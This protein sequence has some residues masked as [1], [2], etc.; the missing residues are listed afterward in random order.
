MYRR[1][2]IIEICVETID[3]DGFLNLSIKTI[4]DRLS[5]KPPSLY[6]HFPGGLDEI[7]ESIMVYGWNQLDIKIARSTVGK[8]RED[9]L[10][11][12]CYSLREFA[13]EHPG[14]FEAIC[15]HNS[16]TSEL[17]REITKGVISSLYSILES[18]Y[19][20]DEEKMHILRSLRGF[21]EGYAMLEL[22]GSFGD[23]ISLDDSFAY[24]V[25]AIISGIMK[26][27]KRDVD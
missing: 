9:G 2:E 17:N 8:S 13:H 19:L 16:Y 4:A 24:G 15:W 11:A 21:V 1:Q 12:M 5:I 18:F 26:G 22:H 14:V 7:K 25:D 3:K 6:K 20:S 23:K 27:E 10:K